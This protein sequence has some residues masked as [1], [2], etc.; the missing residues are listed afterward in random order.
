MGKRHIAETERTEIEAAFIL[1][2]M[3]LHILAEAFFFQLHADQARREGRG[4][5]RHAKI[6]G[7]IGDGADMIFMPMGQDDAEQVVAPILDEAQVRQDQFHAGI[8]GIGKG[9]AEVDHDPLALAAV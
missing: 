9:Q 1:D 2:H 5:Q 6:G 7:Q 3:Q 4:I 8:I